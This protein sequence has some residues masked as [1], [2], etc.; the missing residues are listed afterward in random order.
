MKRNTIGF[1]IIPLAII[2]TIFVTEVH[3]QLLEEPVS[4][5]TEAPEIPIPGTPSM[6]DPLDPFSMIQVMIKSFFVAW[7]LG[8][9]MAI[10]IFINLLRGKLTLGDKPIKIYKLT[11]WF[12]ARSPKFRSWTIVILTGIAGTFVA[13]KGVNSSSFQGV[14][15]PL[16]GGF[17]AGAQF[18][19]S[20]MGW[21]SMFAAQKK[22]KAWME[23]NTK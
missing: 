6:V 3:S 7:Y 17:L 1:V 19:F 21:K 5:M 18:A 23:E 11:D 20:A 10:Y 16:V 15:L 8:I 14:L 4:A 13:V 2:M 22:N 12:E 9:A